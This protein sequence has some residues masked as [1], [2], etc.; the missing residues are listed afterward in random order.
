[1]VTTRKTLSIIAVTGLLTAVAMNPAK[2]DVKVHIGF[3]L[4]S[5]GY[6]DRYDGHH[7]NQYRHHR[8]KYKSRYYHKKRSHHYQSRKRYHKPKHHYRVY[9]HHNRP[10]NYRTPRHHK[11][12]DRGG[13]SYRW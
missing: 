5:I 2:A 6:Y 1:M 3:G 10:K 4:D 7:Y 11:R 8:P 13:R 12:Y 9:K